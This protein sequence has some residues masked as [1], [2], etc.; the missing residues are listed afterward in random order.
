VTLLVMCAGM[1]SRF[2][3]LKQIEPVG[4]HGELIIDY[5]VYDA[6]KAGFDRVV[7]IIRPEME[8]T[9]RE[10]FFNRQRDVAS[11]R[12]Y[13][14]SYVFQ[15]MPTWRE[16]P[17]G[18]T[19]AVLAAREV[20]NEPFCL[21]NADDMYGRDAFQKIADFFNGGGQNALVAFDLKNTV[22]E[23]GTVSRGVIQTSD[24]NVTDIIE[25]RCTC[26]TPSSKVSMNFFGLQPAVMPML[27]EIF[28]D[29]LKTYE[30]HPTYE[31]FLSEN[32]GRLIKEN[33]ITMQM[34]ATDGKWLGF[35]YPD[36]KEPVKAAV[37]E[38]IAKGVYPSPLWS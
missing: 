7:F 18:T 19:A 35:T 4:E 27:G 23:H 29:F 12:G 37:R 26:D 25:R 6:I 11:G 28:A 30:K 3:G 9:F 8:D 16:K 36:D 2:G 38:M 13:E 14:V 22:S 10:K 33:K 34:L 20:I 15:H 32:I 21:I 17:Y 5:S 31:C 1:G 24:G